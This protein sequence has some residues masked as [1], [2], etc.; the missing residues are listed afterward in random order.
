MN[1]RERMIAV[2]I[3]AVLGLFVA[4]YVVSSYRE[5]L[6]S[7]DG[8]LQKLTSEVQKKKAEIAKG[9]SAAKR[10][11]Q[12]EEHSLPSNPDVAAS[13]Y[14]GWLIKTAQTA[15][16]S[17]VKL[18]KRPTGAVKD[19]Y[20]RLTY[21]LN[22]KGELAEVIQFLYEFESMD[23]LHRFDSVKLTPENNSR[24]IDLTCNITALSLKS[25]PRDRQ[26]VERKLEAFKQQPLAAYRDPL[27]NRNFFGAPNQPPKIDMPSRQEAI[28]DRTWEVSIKG[29]DPDPLD[30]LTYELSES[31]DASAKLDPKTGKLSW[32]PTAKGE[33]AFKVVVHDDGLP[34]KSSNVHKFM[35]AVKDPPPKV[36]VKT[37]APKKPPFDDAKYTVLT[38]VTSRNDEGEIWLHI[39][40]R[41]E[42]RKFQVGDDFTI[43]TVKGEV[44]EIGVDDVIL[45]IN[46]T[47]Q[48]LVVGQ[49]LAGSPDSN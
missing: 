36:E 17:D 12:Y 9:Q 19:A 1:P 42:Q 7:K 3:A 46:G 45:S 48:R 35:V 40:S 6:D 39:R 15:G 24:Q 34:S 22:A 32:R 29:V 2:S 5:Q 11:A 14:G 49:S 41:G 23:W 18:D 20:H 4:W 33:F 31:P 8:K 47:P 27:L 30:K 38:A 10:L 21:T 44:L 28:I 13:L 37:E 16:L 25:A 26:L 43:G